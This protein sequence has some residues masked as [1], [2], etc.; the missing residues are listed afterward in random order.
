MKIKLL[1]CFIILSYNLCWGIWP[2]K[3]Y[4]Y[5][6]N[7]FGFKFKT[8]KIRTADNILINTWNIV[9]QKSNK[10]KVTII[11]CGGDSGNMSYILKQSMTLAYQ[12]YNVISFDYR[13]FGNS[14]SFK[15]D[16]T[17][18]F[19]NEFL[20]DFEAVIKYAKKL[21]PNNRIGT[22][23]FS[24]GGY[25][26]LVTKVKLD[27]MIAD[28]PL[29][30]PSIFM[31]RL[32]RNEMQLPYNFREP[33]TKSIPQLYFLGTKDKR[34]IVDD[35]PNNFAILYKGDHVQAD[36][37]LADKFYEIIDSFLSNL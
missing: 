19:Y 28:S 3:N 4:L 6:P 18:L 7:K 20:L 16:T 23:G 25:F 12:G 36:Y 31:N 22:L 2:D 14:Q 17:M 27:F 13:G 26:P 29:V 8:V 9:P 32:Q 35:I 21:Y 11:M 30:S 10:N 15:H 37:I 24:M 34:I 5:T 33:I 1:C